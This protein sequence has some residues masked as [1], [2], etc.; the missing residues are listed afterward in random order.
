MNLF[1]N[2]LLHIFVVVCFYYLPAQSL[3]ATS[4]E[5]YLTRIDKIVGKREQLPKSIYKEQKALLID[6]A[7]KYDI[8]ALNLA[9]EEENDI[10]MYNERRK[11]FDTGGVKKKLIAEW[12]KETKRDWPTYTR[13]DECRHTDECKGDPLEAHHVIP[14]GYNGPNEWWNI[15]PLTMDE[16]TGAEGIHSSLEFKDVF[17]KV[18]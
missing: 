6:Y 17:S 2:P 13:K 8:T 4:F 7:E 16:H 10:K 15:F 12:S 1:F 3:S 14:L 11:A 18:K 9:R 5:D